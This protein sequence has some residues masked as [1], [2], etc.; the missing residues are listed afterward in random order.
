M[1]LSHRSQMQ[2]VTVTLPKEI[3]KE[4]DALFPDMDISALT[5]QL[6]GKYI[7]H[8]KNKHLKKQYTQYYQSLTDEDRAE[9]KELLSDFSA[10]DR[11][12]NAFIE[13]EE[14]NGSS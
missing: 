5:L 14:I 13:A 8:Q 10:L 12:V 11:E 6:L 9:E 1:N 2:S 3:I 4:A 7:R